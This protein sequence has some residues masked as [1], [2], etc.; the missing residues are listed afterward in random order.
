M[1]GWRTFAF[2]VL[3]LVA[4][5][6]ASRD[7][8]LSPEALDHVCWAVV[9]VAGLVAGRNAVDALALG[10]GVKGAFKVLMTDEKPGEVKP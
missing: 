3:S 8:K 7:G 6:L 10:G 4:I 5:L 1:T 9:G 2:G